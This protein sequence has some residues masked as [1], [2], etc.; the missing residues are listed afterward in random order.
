[1]ASHLPYAP[2]PPSPNTHCVLSI[3]VVRVCGEYFGGACVFEYV[4]GACAERN[5][6]NDLRAA[7]H[8]LVA[9]RLGAHAAQC[10]GGRDEAFDRRRDHRCHRRG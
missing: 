5:H 4:G 9:A 1:M 3:S 6:S 7:R 10:G 2:P 8:R